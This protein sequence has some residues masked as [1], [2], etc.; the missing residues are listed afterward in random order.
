M[1]RPL[2]I[3]ALSIIAGFVLAMLIIIPA[4][5]PPIQDI[6]QLFLFMVITGGLTAFVSYVLYWRD[7]ARWFSS[8]RWALLALI[9]LTVALIYVNVWMVAQL[10]FIS[11]HDMVL[12]TALLVFA[13]LVSASAVFFIARS[14]VDRIRALAQASERL[15][16]GDLQVTL[17]VHGRDELAS[18]S[19]TFNRMADTLRSVDEEKRRLEQTRRDL[20]AWVSHDLRTPLAAIRV[21]NEAILDGVAGD[22]QTTTRYMQDMQREIKHLSHLIDDLFELSQHESGHLKIRCEPTSFHDLVSDTI[23]SL[24]IQAA[25]SNIE[26]C[27]QIEDQI[28]VLNIA[29]DKI[30]RV[31]YNLLDNAIRHTPSQGK[32]TLLV[33]CVED[34]VQVSVH[35]TGSVVAP[36]DLPHIFESFYQ[37]ESSRAPAGGRPRGTGLGLA[38]ARAFVEGHGGQMWAQ[39]GPSEGTTLFFTLPRA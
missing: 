14:L 36:T 5:H 10:M 24:T 3:P 35:N 34:K 30:Q 39:S 23:S 17:P 29:A 1:S 26:L 27:G 28:N 9:L 33:R 21:M 11:L 12:T 25:R 13:G 37:G 8:I 38:I 32:V 6:Q 22:P 15:A 18:L 7:L 31:L 4:L 19:R 2:L 16:Q 20:I